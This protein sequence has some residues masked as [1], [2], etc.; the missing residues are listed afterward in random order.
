MSSAPTIRTVTLNP[1]VDEAIAAESLLLG[2]INRCALDAVDPGGKGVNASRVIHRLGRST[3]ALGFVAGVTGD[4]LRT[5]LDAEGVPHAFESVDGLTRINVMLYERASSRRTRLYLPGATVPL[6]R[7]D[8]LKTAL[9]SA[10]AGSIVLLGGSLPPGLPETLYGDLVAWLHAHDVRT[11]VDTS[12]PPLAHALAAR[13]LLIKPSL[14]EAEE[15]LGRRL[16]DTASVV[17][18]ARE[19]QERGAAFVVISRGEDGAI[20]LDAE[21]A[22][23]ARPPAVTACSTVGSGDSMVAALAIALNEGL[24][25]AEGLRLGSAAGAATAITRGTQLCD[26]HE[27]ER[28]LGAVVVRKLEPLFGGAPHERPS[29]KR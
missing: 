1:A 16:P 4:F 10:P 29:E 7:I 24:P 18:A 25:F 17:A 15:L 20:G 14:E 26:P 6:A 12:G 13:P 22:W 21:G 23:E 28:L 8:A 27:I 11:I 2:G 9:A 5:A 19:P 3:L